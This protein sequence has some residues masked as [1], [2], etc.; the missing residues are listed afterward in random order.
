[1]FVVMN[2]QVVFM[3]LVNKIKKWLIKKQGVNKYENL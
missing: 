3:K 1:M 2:G